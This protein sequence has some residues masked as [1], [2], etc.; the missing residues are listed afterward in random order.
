MLGAVCWLTREQRGGNKLLLA[1]GRF[2][3][4]GG[5]EPREKGIR[6]RGWRTEENVAWRG[7]LRKPPGLEG[8][9]V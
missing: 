8:E 3:Q 4:S 6:L 2:R 1:S 5:A 7:L 9:R